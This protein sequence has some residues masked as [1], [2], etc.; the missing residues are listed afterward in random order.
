M[1]FAVDANNE[2]VLFNQ[3]NHSDWMQILDTLGF[4]VSLHERKSLQSYF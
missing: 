1:A 2:N 4:K 3:K